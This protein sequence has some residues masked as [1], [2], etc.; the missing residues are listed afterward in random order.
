[1][2]PLTHTATGLFLSRI[3]LKRW[4]PL[5]TPILLV[6]ANAPDFDIVTLAGGQ[7]NYL[8]FHRHLTHSLAAAPVVAL[9]AVVLVKA[10]ARK[11]VNWIGAWAA[12]LV[13]VA[14]HLAL[15]LTNAYGVRLLLPFSGRWLRLDLTSRIDLW[16]W[17]VLLLALAAPFLARLVGSEIT[18]GAAKP[19]SYGR[20]WA[21]FGLA[22]L[23]IYNYGRS[24]LHTRAVAVLESRIY[25]GRAPSATAAMPDAANPWK[26]HGIV[27]T[28]DFYAFEDLDL[29]RGDFDP[30]QAS[31]LHKPETDPALDAAARTATFRTFLEWAQYP[32]W[33][34]W[35]VSEP[36]NARLVELYD[37]RMGPGIVAWAVVADNGRVVETHFSYGRGRR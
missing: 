17:A 26:W 3:G 32:L 33:R 7:L 10:V 1:M 8:R 15:D 36:E 5:A 12:A 25:R 22:F 11:Q 19:R 9:L 30:T 24:V 21:V 34:V 35:P 4:T 20:G 29:L 14:T 13:A 37:A 27:E 2:D 6:A 16:I 23:L 18:S 31:V 28:G